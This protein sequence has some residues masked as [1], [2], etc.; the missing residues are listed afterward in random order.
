MVTK[1]TKI[2]NG[3]SSLGDAIDNDQRVRKIIRALPPSWEVKAT[4]LK[5]LND[6][7]EM[8]LIG[9]IGNKECTTDHL[10]AGSSALQNTVS[11]IISFLY[12]SP[13]SC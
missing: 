11:A 1:F 5:E 13:Y 7:D 10:S 12:Y 4:T 6:K 3:L 9:L 2:T 8:K